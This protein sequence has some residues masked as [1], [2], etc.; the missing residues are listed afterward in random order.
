MN[1]FVS[2]PCAQL[3][4]V[5]A[6]QQVMEQSA[7]SAAPGTLLAGRRI[8]IAD[9]SSHGRKAV[10]AYLKH[11]GAIVTEAALSFLGVGV[12][13]PELSGRTLTG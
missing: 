6:L 7:G 11:A 9:D 8:L 12:P 3:P 2:K 10:A 5:Q 4:L 13:A 1:G